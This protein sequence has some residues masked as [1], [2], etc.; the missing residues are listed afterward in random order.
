MALLVCPETYATCMLVPLL[1]PFQHMLHISSTDHVLTRMAQGMQPWLASHFVRRGCNTDDIVVSISADAFIPPMMHR[2]VAVFWY[3]MP[4]E[5]SPVVCNASV[6][7]RRLCLLHRVR[8]HAYY[9]NMPNNIRTT[10]KA[11]EHSR[12]NLCGRGKPRLR[13]KA[14]RPKARRYRRL[15]LG[16]HSFRANSTQTVTA[17]GWDELP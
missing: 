16:A 4:S 13:Q 15:V 5:P 11:R 8:R 7:A 12:P 9:N 14:S 1:W 10:R 6:V 17:L 2:A 3:T